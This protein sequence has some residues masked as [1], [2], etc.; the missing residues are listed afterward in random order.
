MERTVQPSTRALTA[1]SLLGSL[2]SL[3]EAANQL[4]VTRSALSH[5][6]AELEERL[7]VALV[8]KEGRRLCLTED[9]ERLLS[10]MGDA[11]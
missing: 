10:S 11:L 3:T 1:L 9:G 4:G 8:R 5:R 6:I 2:G 7:G